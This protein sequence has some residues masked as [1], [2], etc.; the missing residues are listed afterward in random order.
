M[1]HAVRNQAWPVWVPYGFPITDSYKHLHINTMRTRVG[2]VCPDRWG[3]IQGIEKGDCSVLIL[4]FSQQFEAASP[5]PASGSVYSFFSLLPPTFQILATRTILTTKCYMFLHE[6]S[7]G[8]FPISCHFMLLTLGSSHNEPLTVSRTFHNLS[9]PRVF[10]YVV[11]CIWNALPP[12]FWQTLTYP[13]NPGSNIIFPVKLSPILLKLSS[14]PL[15]SFCSGS[16]IYLIKYLFLPTRLWSFQKQGPN[17]I[18]S[19]ASTEPN[20][21]FCIESSQKPR[22]SK[23]TKGQNTTESWCRA[24]VPGGRKSFCCT[25][26]KYTKAPRNTTVELPRPKPVEQTSLLLG[27]AFTRTSGI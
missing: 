25:L 2:Q 14:P 21:D 16:Y 12:P 1:E 15:C 20:S 27:P 4:I 8:H 13:L 17:L 22:M 9:S 18:Y 5:S 10:A 19:Y 7:W 11:H 6:L 23:R 24:C 3:I 26:M